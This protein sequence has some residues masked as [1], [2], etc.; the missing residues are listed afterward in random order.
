MKISL[1]M[2]GHLIKYCNCYGIVSDNAA[3][4]VD[5]GTY[6]ESLFE[7]LEENKNKERAVLITHAHFDHIGGA[8][9][10]RE[11]TGVKIYSSKE[12]APALNDRSLNLSGRFCREIYE[13][14]PDITLSDGQEF[15]VGDLKF[16][17]LLT[18]GH[19]AGSCCYLIGDNLFSGDMLFL[20]TIG[21][22]DLPGNRHDLVNDSLKKLAG[23]QDNV[24]V[25]PGHGDSTTIAHEKQYNPYLRNK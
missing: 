24:N 23:L 6:D 25:F 2:G 21:R 15:L 8:E 16:K 22:T 11:K 18:P 13:F 4:I 7:F 14:N 19:T 1:L 5:P 3:V 12:D 10:L 17:A 9:L 20:E